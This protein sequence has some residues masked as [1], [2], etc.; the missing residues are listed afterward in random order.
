MLGI[1]SNMLL[2]L[3]KKTKLIFLNC[4]CRDLKL[5]FNSHVF[6][7]WRKDFPLPKQEGIHVQQALAPSL[8]FH[9]QQQPL[10][11]LHLLWAALW[12][13]R[14]LPAWTPGSGSWVGEEV[15]GS[16]IYFC[17]PDLNQPLLTKWELSA[18][19]G[20]TQPLLPLCLLNCKDAF[21]QIKR[22]R[23]LPEF[24]TSWFWE[25]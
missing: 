2:S 7:S 20:D 9:H 6:M 22:L 23:L 5:V 17:M 11:E 18:I 16:V 14:V 13:W 21:H 4:V 8:P 25:F 15:G 12:G 1:G 19:R 3:Q 10:P 24:Q